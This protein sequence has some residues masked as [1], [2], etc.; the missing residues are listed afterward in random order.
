[1]GILRDWQCRAHGNFESSEESPLCPYGCDTVEKIFLQ[2][3]VFRSN[4]TANIDRTLESL[5]KSHGLTDMNNRGGH[6]VRRPSTDQVRQQDEFNRFIHERYGD[7]WGQ[8]PKGGT[9]NVKTKEITGAG[10]GVGAALAQYHGRADNVLSEVREAGA[11]VP[12]PVLVRQ[13]HENL[14]VSDARPPG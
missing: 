5:A 8:I 10:P 9:L 11:L 12:K 6:A 3:A 4:R 14:K 1:M 2:P 7:G 13:D